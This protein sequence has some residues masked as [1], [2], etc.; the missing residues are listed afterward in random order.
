M[1]HFDIICMKLAVP[2]EIQREIQS[3]INSNVNVL[4]KCPFLKYLLLNVQIMSFIL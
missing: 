1:P 4:F 3:T 2:V